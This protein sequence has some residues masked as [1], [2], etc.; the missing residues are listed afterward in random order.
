MKRLFR[1]SFKVI[2]DQALMSRTIKA[3]SRVATSLI[4]VEPIMLNLGECD[5]GTKKIISLN[6]INHSDLP[7]ETYLDIRSSAFKILSK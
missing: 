6:I 4:S 1:I 7:T 3:R 2:H 5:V